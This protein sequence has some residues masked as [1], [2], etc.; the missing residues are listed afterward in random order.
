MPKITLGEKE[1]PVEPPQ[2]PFQEEVL[3]PP[4]PEPRP[5]PQDWLSN[6]LET[7]K[8]AP[9]PVVE[10]M[11]RAI[12][13]DQAVKDAIKQRIKETHPDIAAL[14]ELVCSNA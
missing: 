11:K 2:L 3:P 6:L 7:L 9:P 13:S 12:A 5:Q 10:A 4:Q 1:K 8:S 14:L